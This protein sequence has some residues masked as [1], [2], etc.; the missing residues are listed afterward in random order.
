M[1][2]NTDSHTRKYTYIDIQTSLLWSPLTPKVTDCSRVRLCSCGFLQQMDGLFNFDAF[3]LIT[4][5][6]TLNLD[7]SKLKL[8]FQNQNTQAVLYCMSQTVCKAQAARCVV[9]EGRSSFVSNGNLS[10]PNTSL[11]FKI[12]I[13]S[14]QVKLK[15]LVVRFSSLATQTYIRTSQICSLTNLANS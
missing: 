8:I 7:R 14:K 6:N 3:L 5:G 15:P 11:L 9:Q 1:S 10:E 12:E 2:A 13:A 4:S